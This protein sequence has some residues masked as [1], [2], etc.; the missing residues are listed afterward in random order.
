MRLGEKFLMK[1]LALGI[2]R[3]S[4]YLCFAAELDAAVKDGKGTCA[5]YL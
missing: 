3:A 2:T 1:I 4:P 5:W